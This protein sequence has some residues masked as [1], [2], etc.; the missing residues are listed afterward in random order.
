MYANFFQLKG[1]T[2]S[3]MDVDDDTSFETS[4]GKF[5]LYHSQSCCECVRLEK[6]IGNVEDVL[7][8]PILIAEDGYE[9]PSGEEKRKYSSSYTW[10]R[11]RLVSAKGEFVMYFLGESN[12]YYSETM[13]FKKVN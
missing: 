4:I 5:S 9:E 10:S 11:Y 12:G 8:S 1:C 2:I 7:N 3:K 6:T 13:T